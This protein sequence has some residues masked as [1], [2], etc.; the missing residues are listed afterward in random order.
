MT[1]LK[2]K[3]LSKAS[4]MENFVE[5][6]NL[7]KRFGEKILFD[8]FSCEIKQGDFV[9]ITGESGCG[10]HVKIRLS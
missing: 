6:K 7:S 1:V 2:F 4:D 8:H 9:V 10:G 5:I 3:E